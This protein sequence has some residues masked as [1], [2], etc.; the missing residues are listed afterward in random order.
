[1]RAKSSLRLPRPKD[2]KSNKLED[3]QDHLRKLYEELDKAW[4]LL[5]QDVSTIQ[6]DED[7]WIYFGNKDTDGTYRIGRDGTAWNMERR[8][9][10]TYTK[11]A[12]ATA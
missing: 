12:A 3:I 4:R 5:W 9:S 2:L 1:M 11:K 6:V 10:G 7:G 8:E